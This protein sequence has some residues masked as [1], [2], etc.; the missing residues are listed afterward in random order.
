LTGSLGSRRRQQGVALITAILV[1]ALAT[2]ASV[3]IVVAGHVGQARTF[4]L[5]DSERAWWYAKG[6]EAWGMS[7]LERDRQDNQ[8]D[9]LGEIWAMGTPP[10]PI[11]G[12]ALQG[13]LEDAQG[14]FNL[15]NFAVTDPERLERSIAQFTRL[16]AC[17]EAADAFNATD[18]INAIID[19]VD[20]DDEQR[21]P[22]GGEDISYLGLTP[23][24]R[25][26][27][28]PM[29]SPS[30]LRAIQGF[31]SEMMTALSPH[32]TALPEPTPINLNTAT[33]AVLCSL[34]EDPNTLSRIEAFLERRE[35][36]PL[37]TVQ[38]AFD[39]EG[40]FSAA[41]TSVAPEDLSVSSRYFIGRAD[42]FVGSGGVVLYSL[43]H[44]P[45]QGAPMV[46]RR[47]T[48]GE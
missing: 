23:P 39:Q 44:R 41:D 34:S 45:D 1:V 24:Y 3:A 20:A 27:N 16:L 33:S 14:R 32:V 5:F 46:I 2:I 36:F 22:G 31:T 7:I 8:T 25:V 30:E 47:S 15:N 10:L 12:G 13:S 19:W 28:Q 6:M 38:Q 21:F 35:E 29:A 4:L 18:L 26:A 17:S 40:I 42:A 43:I 9:H 48:A 37:E 11:E